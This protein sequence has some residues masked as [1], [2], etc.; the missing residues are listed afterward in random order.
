[1]LIDSQRIIRAGE[2]RRNP[3]SNPRLIS[4]VR[5]LV[6]ADRRLPSY[7]SRGHAPTTEE[8]R[9]DVTAIAQRTR[10]ATTI[11]YSPGQQIK[12]RAHPRLPTI[13]YHPD[14]TKALAPQFHCP[15]C[16]GNATESQFLNLK[17]LYAHNIQMHGPRLESYMRDN[18]ARQLD[19]MK[20]KA[21]SWRAFEELFI[22]ARCV[23]AWLSFEDLV[24]IERS[25]S[26]Y[27]LVLA[28]RPVHR[29]IGDESL[30]FPSVPFERFPT[31]ALSRHLIWKE[32]IFPECGNNT[33]RHGE[34]LKGLPA[35]LKH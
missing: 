22:F 11:E 21:W 34:M 28:M 35:F 3:V 9:S 15:F 12:I 26:S 33:D 1:M 24:E 32:L 10:L 4:P 23:K 27:R 31:I 17:T 14:T 30:N 5:A 8:V 25:E 6:S 13:C 2:I 18:F 19:E 16:G 29:A 20:V 7:A